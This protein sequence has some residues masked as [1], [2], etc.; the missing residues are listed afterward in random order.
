MDNES[1][2][3]P[4]KK[5]I[6]IIILVIIILALVA[7]GVAFYIISNKDKSEEG[8]S[9]YDSNIILSEDDITTEKTE[10]GHM[11]LEMKT[12]AVSD[13]GENF[14]CYLCNADENSYDIYITIA[15]EDD[16]E[17]IFKSGVMPLGSRIETFTTTK[18]LEAGDYNTI[19]TFHQLESD[20]VTE[21]SKVSV[22]YT[23][24]VNE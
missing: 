15:T 7:G 18:K 21:H 5:N 6:V 8:N 23:L 22:A 24:T 13:D 9:K 2:A 12:N 14:T 19:I 4:Q 10:S 17:E 3:T 20:G 1:K 11:T 16:N